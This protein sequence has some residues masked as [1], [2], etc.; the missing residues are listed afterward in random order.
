M[1]DGGLC[2]SDRFFGSRAL[3]SGPAGG[4]VGMVHC[5]KLLLGKLA[6]KGVIG[7]DMGGT[8]TDVSVYYPNRG[9]EV[10]SESSISG[11]TVNTPCFDI[12]TVAA[13]GGSILKFENGLFRVGPESSG[14][15]PG[16]R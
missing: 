7:F 15:M 13:G 4:V 11:I 14:A 16:P 3:L 9:V 2:E 5:T 6:L 1:S 12:N 8:S 10:S